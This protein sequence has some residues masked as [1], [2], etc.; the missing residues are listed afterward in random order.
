MAT[1]V[2]QPPKLSNTR[3]LLLGA[4]SVVLC[5]SY[6]MAVFTPFPVSM[7]VVLYGRLKGYGVALLGF[8]VSVALG[9]FL[10]GD[11]TLSVFYGCL[12]G[13]AVI[14]GETMKRGW[15]PIRAIITSGLV[16]MGACTLLVAVLSWKLS[17][18]PVDFFVGEVTTAIQKLELAKKDGK[19]DQS[20]VDLGLNRPPQEIAREV[21]NLVPGYLFIT[22]FFVMWVNMFLAL[23][24]QRLLR[25]ETSVAWDERALMTFK[26]PFFWAYVVALALALVVG[27]DAMKWAWAEPVG[28]NLLRMLGVFYFFQGFGV[29]LDYLNHFH[30]LGFFR[31]LIVMSIILVMPALI[32]IFGLFDTWFDFTKKLSKK[33][34]I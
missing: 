1:E 13:V 31:T 6:L 21:V 33:E 32:A 22:V 3:L 8:A 18:S 15:N 10:T 5:L 14:V 24:G 16:F 2:L 9:R 17:V 23:K 27:A 7:A 34:K 29:L 11:Y 25:T 20:L 19:F 4:S 30:V 26:M 28:M 12:L